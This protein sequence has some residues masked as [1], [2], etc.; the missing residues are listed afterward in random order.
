[1]RAV[2]DV[3]LWVRSPCG[4]RAVSYRILAD[5]VVCIHFVW[6]VF[7][8]VGGVWGRRRMWLRII[9][10]AGLALALVIQVFDWYCPL[11]HLEAWLR[12]HHDPS[13]QYSGSFI[14]YYLE[15]VLYLDLSR[16]VVLLF[17][18]ILLAL[19]AW[20]YLRSDE[21]PGEGAKPKHPVA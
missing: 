6:I 3:L 2:G 11:T 9:H 8:F 21:A 10:W 1:V 14:V 7:L 17:T 12:S 13:L 19:N 16:N 20:L 15:K 4:R 5:I 18:F